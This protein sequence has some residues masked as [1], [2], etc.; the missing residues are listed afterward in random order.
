MYSIPLDKD[1]KIVDLEKKVGTFVFG[2]EE[3][4]DSESRLQT[5]NFWMRG[6]I[7]TSIF[8]KT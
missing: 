6:G 4:K 5:A 2:E 3:S 8:K 7:L 1:N